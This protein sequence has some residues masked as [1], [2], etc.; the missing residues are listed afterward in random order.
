FPAEHPYD[1]H[2]SRFAVF[3][4]FISP[5]DPIRGVAGQTRQPIH[6]EQPANSYDVQI[7]HKTK[8][9][10]IRHEVLTLPKES[11]KKPLYWQGENHF[12]QVV[13][14][15]GNRQNFYPTP[16]KSVA[17]N[18]QNRPVEHKV[19]EK[20]ADTM[21]NIERSHWLTSNQ[22]DYAGLGPSNPM[23][24][25]NLEDKKEH[26]TNTGEIDNNLYSHFANTFDPPRPH[27]GRI[28]R[29]SL[30]EKKPTMS[31]QFQNNLPSTSR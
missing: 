11:E 9:A 18:L 4:N 5:E 23:K 19:S 25:N 31:E 14:T 17:P 8:G 24:L 1:S 6:A 26:F 7:L 30:A 3:P 21:R 2:I 28:A 12:D 27:E 16:P 10:G 29:L 20:T 13:K 22:L 15:H